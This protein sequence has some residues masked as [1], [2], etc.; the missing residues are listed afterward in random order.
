MKFTRLLA[1][2]ATAAFC[3]VGSA[4]AQM[5][6]EEGKEFRRVAKPQAT[7][8]GGKIEVVEFFSFSCP[9]CRAFE[10]ILQGW[11]KSM[12][13]D[14]QLRRV[15][16][17]FLQH[18]P[19]ISKILYTL[20]ALGDVES[21][22]PAVFDAIQRDNKKLQDKDAFYAWAASRN[23]DA[24]KVKAAYEGFSVDSKVKRSDQMGKAFGIE[25]VPMVVVDGKFV[26]GP[27]ML[28]NDMNRV[29]AALDFLIAMARKEKGK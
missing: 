22:V 20:E 25:S 4:S 16:V 28:G 8:A 1:T 19:Q 21:H 2:F 9:A 5:K 18:G 3:A 24:A 7:E 15:H 26:T 23:L 10:P 13:A 29:P 17:N 14:V 6:M 12:P 27:G 11:K